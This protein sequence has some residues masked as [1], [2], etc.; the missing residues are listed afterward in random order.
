[1]RV[2]DDAPRISVV[3]PSR[4][5][6]AHLEEAITSVVTQ[7]CKS[8]ELILVDDGSR[9]GT[10]AC[11]DAWQRKDERI[12]AVH[13]WPNRGLPGALNE[14]FRH[15]RGALFT[16]TSDDNAYAPGALE[17]ML[18]VL[19][20]RDEVDLLYTDYLR[21]DDGGHE[22]P[23]RGGPAAAL[24]FENPVGACFLY[25][26]ELHEE[27][28]GYDEGLPLA[29]D[30][31][32]WLRANVRFRL[33]PLHETLYRYRSHPGSLTSTRGSRVRAAAWRAVDGQLLSLEP[34]QRARVLL[35]WARR[36]AA[37]GH[38]AAARSN[39]ARA[40]VLAPSL[41]LRGE[42]A[43]TL[44]RACTGRPLP[45]PRFR[46]LRL[47]LPDLLGGVSSHALDLAR[48]PGFERRGARLLWLHDR[49]SDQARCPEA[50]APGAER[51]PHRWPRE[52]A[53]AVLRRMHRRLRRDR[54]AILASEFFGLAYAARHAPEAPL[55]QILHGDLPYYYDLAERF[56]PWV[57]AFVAVSARVAEEARRRLP[58]RAAD[59]H[60]LP[61]G[62]P[63]AERLRSAVGGPLRLVYCGRF[64]AHK[65]VLDLP[66]IDRRLRAEGAV[67]H[68]TLIGSGPD[69]QALRRAFGPDA[70]VTFCG[71]LSRQ[72]CRARLSD[73]DVFVLPSYAE[74]LP[75]SLLEAMAAGVVPV[76]SD[77]ASG[78]RE[79]VEDG[80]T[81]LLARPGEPGE[82]AG[83]ILRLHRGRDL[84][85]DCSRAAA[86]RIRAH[87]ALEDRGAALLDLVCD[88]EALPPR[89]KPRWTR[90][91]SR[92]DRPWLP[93]FAVRALRSLLQ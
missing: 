49:A 33:E 82:F 53:F 35:H 68:W 22:E 2:R 47:V 79:V 30:Y 8:W 14:G 59:V 88:L 51:I 87:H 7:T 55:V 92:L 46:T 38:G 91:P 12:R 74:G 37:G 48:L 25:R 21:F 41:A 69:E 18:A 84:L 61:S 23:V 40:L 63:A 65:G 1:M 28:G 81:G 42:H 62:V 24:P 73:H 31:D 11:M 9:D 4:D 20:D 3:L 70:P 17:R 19:D 60:H 36:L 39:L 77:L 43:R 76:V 45:R 50:H 72:D 52:S 89:D 44:W 80:A 13:L 57:D 78:I 64:D 54:G 67:G 85:E 10:G 27:L 5:G 90:G 34:A 93:G 15:A 6:M 71:A 26:R 58:H 16:W 32:F 75:L 83:A 29:E 86:K 66:E 56:E